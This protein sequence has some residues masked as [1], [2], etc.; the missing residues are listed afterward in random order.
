MQ[1]QLSTLIY[2]YFQRLFAS[3][4]KK[5]NPIILEGGQILPIKGILVLNNVLLRKIHCKGY[6]LGK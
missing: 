4:R 2:L 5:Y 3:N 1:N 6:Y